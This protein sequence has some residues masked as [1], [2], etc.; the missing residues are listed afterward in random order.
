MQDAITQYWN[1]PN[2]TADTFIGKVT[3]AMRDA[4]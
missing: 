3:A 4:S 2:M 1:S